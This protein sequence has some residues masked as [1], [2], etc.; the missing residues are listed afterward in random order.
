MKKLYILAGDYIVG[1][2]MET[3]PEALAQIMK[4]HGKT[5]ATAESCTGGAIASKITAMAGASTFFNGGVVA[6]SNAVK[7]STLGVKSKTLEMHGAVSEETVREMAT[8]VRER[9]GADYGVATSGI[10]G[11]GGGT[12]EKPVGTVWIALAGPDGVETRLKKY[13]DDRI[14]TIERT[15]NEVFSMLIH[16]IKTPKEQ[17]Q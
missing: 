4:L 10:A 9:L 8:G 13:G 12:A 6:Y 11:P 15:C 5:L 14:R 17:L 16:S 3:L 2:D 7:M 1:E